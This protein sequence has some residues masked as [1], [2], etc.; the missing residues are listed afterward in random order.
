MSAYRNSEVL[1]FVPGVWSLVMYLLQ[2]V[3]AVIFV[4]CLRETG[5]G[6]LVGYA[7]AIPRS[8]TN[9]GWYSIVRHPLYFFSTLYMIL[10]PVMTSQWLLLTIMGTL[11]FLIGALIEEQRLTATF[12]ETYRHYQQHVPFFIPNPI[13][14]RTHTSNIFPG[15]LK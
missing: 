7:K 13:K 11:Y 12:G 15:I 3:V 6:E 9:S 8:F 14:F 10:N 1:Y 4:L 5:V 2:L